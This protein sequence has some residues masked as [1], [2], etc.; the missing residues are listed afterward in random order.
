MFNKKILKPFLILLVLSLSLVSFSACDDDDEDKKLEIIGTWQSAYGGNEVITKD[1]W[2]FT[3]GASTIVEYDNDK[4]IVYVQNSADME[5]N[6]SKFSKIVYTD[7]ADNKF[8][9]C[10]ISFGNETLDDAKANTTEADASDP[11]T[12]GCGGNFPWTSLTK[13]TE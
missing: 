1:T 4:N 9:Y 7:I 10:T 3:F 6:A 5:Y 12:T 13:A 2:T 8:Y 11:A